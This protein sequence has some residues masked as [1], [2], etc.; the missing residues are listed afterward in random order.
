MNLEQSQIVISVLVWAIVGGAGVMLA[1]AGWI[2]KQL[3]S[4]LKQIRT[5]LGTTN[6]SLASIERDLRKDLIHLDRRVTRV[7]V[8]SGIRSYLDEGD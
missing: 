1:V 5:T 6:A 8:H 7:E 3:Q 2:G 4:E